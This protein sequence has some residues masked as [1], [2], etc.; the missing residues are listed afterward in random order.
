MH[1]SVSLAC[2]V[3]GLAPGEPVA[4]PTGGTVPEVR[5]ER[6]VASLLGTLGGNAGSCHG[7]FQGRGGFRLSLFGHDPEMDFTALT[8]A[9][10]GRRVDRND[11]DRSLVLLKATGQV[12]HGGEKRFDR[13]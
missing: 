3:L 4:L 2:A 5:F 7:S 6:H 13:D 12:P 11:P 10:L 9:T 8:R 1:L